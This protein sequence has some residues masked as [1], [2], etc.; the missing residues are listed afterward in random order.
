MTF[1]EP[2]NPDQSELKQISAK[3]LKEL[4]RSSKEG[5]QAAEERDAA[6][7]ELA[8]FKAGVDLSHP[9]A[10]YFVKGYAGEADPEAVK[11]EWERITGNGGQPSP[12]EQELAA[13][14][15]GQDLTAG[16]GAIAP[17]KLAERNQKLSE[18]S[19]TD[20]RYDEKFAR[21]MDEYGGQMGSLVG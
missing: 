1:V 4:K 9:M 21:I 5:R 19:P 14:N 6:V 7:R 8:F 17:D 18:L 3:D 20:P 13:M 10:D 12:T 16:P 2:E 11:A 15:G